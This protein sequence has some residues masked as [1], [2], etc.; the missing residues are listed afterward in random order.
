VGVSIVVLVS[1]YDDSSTPN[2]REHVHA[3]YVCCKGKCDE[4]LERKYLRKGLSGGWENL[5]DLC[6]PTIYIQWLMA[7]LNKLR[8][9]L[10]TYEQ[11]AFDEEKR[12]LITL[13][14]RVARSL[15]SKEKERV[16]DLMQIP[17]HLGG[18][19]YS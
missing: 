13:F 5:G 7:S 8:A 2:F 1:T 17:A 15:T 10:V 6:I 19:G 18:L 14:S 9:G 3:V 12:I 11:E 16:K 4:I